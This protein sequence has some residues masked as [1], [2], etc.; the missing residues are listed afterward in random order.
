VKSRDE[1]G[2]LLLSM[3]EMAEKITQMKQAETELT[4]T[5]TQI[6]IARRIQQ[7]LFPSEPPQVQGVRLA[8]RCVPAAQVGGDYFDYFQRS[9]NSVDIFI[10]D[11]SGH[12]IGSALLMAEAR[13]ILKASAYL[14]NSAA[15]IFTRLN[16]S[17]YDDLDHAEQFITMFYAKY[18]AAT[19]L[20]S[21]ASAGHNPPMLLRPAAQQCTLLDAE[22]MILGIRRDIHFEEKQTQLEPGDIVFFY[23][24]GVT[25]ATDPSGQQYGTARLHAFLL[26]HAADA[27]EQMVAAALAELKQFCQ[28]ETFGDDVTIVVMSVD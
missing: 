26:Q 24:D 12:G 1:M 15:E 16:A 27:P 10:S 25:E 18:S 14:T 22:G 3:Q 11:V 2:Q 19:R 20:L 17:L 28:C 13:S 8:G 9:E 21:Y 7:S 5:Y 6:A 4:V 23:T